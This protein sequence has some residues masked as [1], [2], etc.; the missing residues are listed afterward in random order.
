MSHSSSFPLIFDRNNCLFP[1]ACCRNTSASLVMSSIM[2]ARI[3]DHY[4]VESKKEVYRLHSP[5]D[6]L[7]QGIN[8]PGM[9]GLN[10]PR[11]KVGCGCHSSFSL[12]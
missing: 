6:A 2:K 5:M 10:C 12:T 9:G 8:W 7:K 11:A 4:S 1:E 3:T